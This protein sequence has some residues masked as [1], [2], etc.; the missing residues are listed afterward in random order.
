MH[1]RIFLGWAIHSGSIVRTDGINTPPNARIIYAMESVVDCSGRLTGGPAC[2]CTIAT[3]AP[4]KVRHAARESVANIIRANFLACIAI[5]FVPIPEYPLSE[6]Q[7]VTF[8]NATI[9]QGFQ[10][11]CLPVMRPE[12]R[13]IYSHA[14]RSIRP[15]RR[16]PE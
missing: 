11:N 2:A 15:C 3:H 8:A 4:K 6:D 12:P 9:F 10:A 5:S 13:T 14:A 1:R 7:V 16:S